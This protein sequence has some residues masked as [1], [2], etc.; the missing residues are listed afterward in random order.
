MFKLCKDLQKRLEPQSTLHKERNL[1][2]L[3]L[4]VGKVEDLVSRVPSGVNEVKFH[5][6]LAIKGIVK[7]APPPK[8]APKPELNMDDETMLSKEELQAEAYEHY[9]YDY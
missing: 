4:L 6:E 2:E 8:P 7:E 5:L 9:E 3:K 1:A